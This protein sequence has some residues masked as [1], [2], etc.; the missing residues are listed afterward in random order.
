MIWPDDEKCPAESALGPIIHARFYSMTMVLAAVTPEIAVD[1]SPLLPQEKVTLAATWSAGALAERWHRLHGMDV[2]RLLASAEASEIRLYRGEQTGLGFFSP[3][4]VAGDGAFYADLERFD[5]YYIPH[6]WEHDVAVQDLSKCGR[7]LEVGCAEGSFVQRL[8]ADKTA[9]G[10]ELN[11]TAVARAKAKGL[12]VESVD[13]Y[14]VARERGG[15]FDAVCAFQ[16]LEHVPNP[17]RFIAALLSLVKAG[18]R[19]I[20]SV[21]NDDS[22]QGKDDRNV[23]NMPPHHLTLWK[24]RTMRS[25]ESLFPMRLVRMVEEPL[26]AYHADYYWRV[27]LRPLFRRKALRPIANFL[28]QRVLTPSLTRCGP[29]R[30]RIAGHTLYACFEKT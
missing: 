24:K 6:K 3:T 15:Q 9:A 26:A 5:W 28:R 10:I 13:L 2:S 14:D 16:V 21:P 12:P 7:V 19:V 11:A 18:G 8:L 17:T 25:L 29:V 23:L 30:K 4:S 1:A 27:K 20:V 22:F